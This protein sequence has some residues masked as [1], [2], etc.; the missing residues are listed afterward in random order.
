[1]SM[2]MNEVGKKKWAKTVQGIQIKVR[3]NR[4]QRDGEHK[5][6]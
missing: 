6:E 4:I 1:M 3:G 5:V 2:R